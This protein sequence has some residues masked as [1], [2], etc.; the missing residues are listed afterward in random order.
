MLAKF[1]RVP[2]S[3]DELRHGVM[4]DV[5]D[6]CSF[7]KLKSLWVNSSGVSNRISG[8]PIENS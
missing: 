3:D 4:E 8:V 7:G 5:V 6:L 1:L 2:F